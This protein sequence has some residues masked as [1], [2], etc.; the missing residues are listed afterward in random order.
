MWR[1][2]PVLVT[3]ATG[4]LGHHLIRA[5]RMQ[6]KAEVVGIVRDAV[7]RSRIVSAFTPDISV[8][9]DVTD[10]ALIERTLAE[11]RIKTVFHLAA[12]TQVRVAIDSPDRNYLG[13]EEPPKHKPVCVCGC[14]G[15][16][17]LRQALNNAEE[18]E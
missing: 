1:D 6:H 4:L 8:H 9:G 17:W 10:Q 7:P 3:G 13:V 12:Q 11:Y 18:L 2:R 16:D 14:T 15:G 5:L